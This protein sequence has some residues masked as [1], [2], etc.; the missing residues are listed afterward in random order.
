MTLTKV[1]DELVAVELCAPSAS[2]RARGLH[3]LLEGHA[4]RRYPRGRRRDNPTCGPE[5][6][7]RGW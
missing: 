2:A 6:L 4:T 1:R 5:W 3:F 7:F